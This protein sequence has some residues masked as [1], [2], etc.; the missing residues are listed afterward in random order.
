MDCNCSSV[1]VPR[2]PLNYQEN[3]LSKN[4]HGRFIKKIN[5][6]NDPK[7]FNETRTSKMKIVDQDRNLTQHKKK[8]P[9]NY[10]T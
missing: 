2:Q 10:S 4:Y 9:F 8:N 7:H 1:K 5:S 6:E 3:L